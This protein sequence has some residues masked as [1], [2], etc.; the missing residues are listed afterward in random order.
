MK[1]ETE[2][3]FRKFGTYIHAVKSKK[4]SK[5]A[6]MLMTC[7]REVPDSNLGRDTSYLNEIF[8]HFPQ[9]I[10]KDDA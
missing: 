2:N 8:R 7:L 5:L 6:L 1:I 3:F 4:P 9:I 10:E